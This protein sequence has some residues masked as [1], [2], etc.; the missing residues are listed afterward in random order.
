ML[1]TAA[2]RGDDV[3]GLHHL[4]RMHPEVWHVAHPRHMGHRRRRDDCE[5]KRGQNSNQPVDH[6]TD[7]SAVQKTVQW[8]GPRLCLLTIICS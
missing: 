5:R 8:N 2:W 6:A 3:F 4:D 1:I 7:I